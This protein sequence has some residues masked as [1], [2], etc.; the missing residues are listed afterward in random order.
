[1]LTSLLSPVWHEWRDGGLNIC[2][3]ADDVKV[4]N[5]RNDPRARVVVYDQE[6]P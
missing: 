6:P 1:M 4:R 2:A 5:V 3:A